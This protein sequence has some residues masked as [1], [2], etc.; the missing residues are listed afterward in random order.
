MTQGLLDGISACS[1]LV[2]EGDQPIMHKALLL[3]TRLLQLLLLTERKLQPD[4][5]MQTVPSVF[6]D[7]NLKVVINVY[8]CV[9]G[10]LYN[11]GGKLSHFL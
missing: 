9:C 7:S 11:N 3:G 4:S 6:Y 8:V 10:G 5:L 2:S 1:H